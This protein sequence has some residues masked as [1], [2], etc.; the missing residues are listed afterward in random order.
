MRTARIT[1]WLAAVV[2]TSL[3]AG[4]VIVPYKPKAEVERQPEP[5]AGP[6]NILVT[7]GPRQWIAEV[8][9][10]IEDEDHGIKVVPPQEFLDVAFL[11]EDASFAKMLEPVTCAR[12]REQLGTDYLVLVGAVTESTSDEHG[13]MAL[14][15]GFYG[16]VTQKEDATAAATVIDLANAR[17]LGSL[18]SHASGR[19]SGI[20]AF[21][22]L[23]VVPMTSSS[24]R[25]GLARAVVTDIRAQS[26]PGKLR[27]AVLAAEP[28]VGFEFELKMPADSATGAESEA[29][30]PAEPATDDARR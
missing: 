16:A 19:T 8:S 12:V 26:G 22:G 23:F 29:A 5:Q 7:A 2:A 21:Y 18:S 13:G 11:D 30:K 25:D 3:A 17:P 15:I 27:V 24:A 4:C 6:A 1:R 14:Y 10:A 20:G 28:A 9:G